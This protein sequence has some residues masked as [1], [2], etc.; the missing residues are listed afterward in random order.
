MQS[1][2]NVLRNYEVNDT[3]KNWVKINPYA[4]TDADISASYTTKYGSAYSFKK[5]GTAKLKNINGD[6][7]LDLMVVG[8]SALAPKSSGRVTQDAGE[9]TTIR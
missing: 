3:Q 2:S 6:G 8:S 9:N 7:E 5:F 1:A 4:L